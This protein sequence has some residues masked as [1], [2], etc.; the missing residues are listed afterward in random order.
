MNITCDTCRERWDE[1]LNDSPSGASPTEA[2]QASELAQAREHLAQCAQCQG[3]FAL[4]QAARQELH[5]FPVMAAPVDLRARIRQQLEA[6]ASAATPVSPIAALEPVMTQEEIAEHR[7]QLESKIFANTGDRFK[8]SPTQR[9]QLLGSRFLQSLRHPAAMALSSGAALLLI[10]FVSLT[11]FQIEQTPVQTDPSVAVVEQ[12][13]PDKLEQESAE[14]KPANPSTTHKAAPQRSTPKSAAASG[15]A[16]KPGSVTAREKVD[17]GDKPKVDL[18]TPRDDGP[19][20]WNT[21]PSHSVPKPQPSLKTSPPTIASV[22]A[23]ANTAASDARDERASSKVVPV[24]SAP[25]QAVRVP[26]STS[27]EI[28]AA[29]APMTAYENREM[30][31]DSVPADNARAGAGARG[32]AGPSGP[33]AAMAQRAPQLG[34][35]TQKSTGNNLYL[36]RRRRGAPEKIEASITAPR[37]IGNA[38]IVVELP[39]EAQFTDGSRSRVLWRGAV[40]KDESIAVKFEAEVE[41]EAED[42]RVVLK[43]TKDGE[44]ETVAY[45]NVPVGEAGRRRSR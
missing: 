41:A 28:A 11:N 10:C 44:T 25:P 35:A 22:P 40:R 38:E 14:Y 34:A 33:P 20:I 37:S 8:D 4:L 45:K 1:L 5:V 31:A 32:P 19:A 13:P 24:P 16:Q 7:A 21:T 36:A 29:P 15:A 26:Q 42:A 23:T 3:E 30:A 18:P 39:E 17:T 6:E 43:E 12:E 2:A 9:L 27:P